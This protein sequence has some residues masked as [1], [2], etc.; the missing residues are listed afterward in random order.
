MNNDKICLMAVECDDV[1]YCAQCPM[2]DVRPGMLAEIG[3]MV[4]VI[5]SVLPV[6][7]G[8]PVD[9]FVRQFT[10]IPFDAK[11]VYSQCWEA[12]LNA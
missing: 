2:V 12:H 7:L 10:G 1:L 11:R 5:R 6:T 3:D 9:Q 4:G 8:S